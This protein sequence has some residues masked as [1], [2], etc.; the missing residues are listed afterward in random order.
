MSEENNN[1]EFDKFL[2]DKEKGGDF[3]NINEET[4]KSKTS[5]K[6][7]VEDVDPIEEEI[8]KKGLGSVNMA[9]YGRQ[10]AESSDT[11]LGYVPLA[12]ETLFSQGRFY[13]Q[14]A[15]ISI[16]S[17]K[18]AEIRHF[19]T[20]QEENI[21]DIEEKLNNIVKSCMRFT[22]RSKK[23]SYKDLMEED[24]IAVLLAIRDLT[25]PEPESK[26]EI[27]AEN[28]YGEKR[29]VEIATRNF[30]ATQIPEEI[31]KYY[32]AV[33]RCFRIQT[34]S[35]GEI[36]MRPP[37]IGVMEEVTKYIKTQQES[38]KRWDQAFV[39]ILPYIQLDWRGFNTKEIFNQEVAFQGW[40]ERKY[41]V[42]YRLAEKMKI[43]AQP[44][45]EV[46]VEGE[47]VMV[48]LDFPGGIKSLFIISDLAGELL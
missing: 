33:A 22:S 31:E 48:P 41:M 13:P 4:P 12:M 21:L 3:E 40:D 44:E 45:M 35:S 27:M 46:D 16:R 42:I 2:N 26:L 15:Q 17:A 14:D 47:A 29:Q 25:F 23:L 5:K 7:K 19:S 6:E 30:T 32:D 38:K 8:S 11:V 18:V 34:K 10:Q 36:L 28:S 43:G 37:S 24:R 20:M 39:Q 1:E 9:N